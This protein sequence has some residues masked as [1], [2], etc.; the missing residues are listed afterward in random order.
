VPEF[1][2]GIRS[3]N[4]AMMIDFEE[5]FRYNHWANLQLLDQVEKCCTTPMARLF[6]HL[7]NAHHIWNQR[8]LGTTEKLTVWSLHELETVRTYVE[9]N[10]IETLEL[11]KSSKPEKVVHYRSS[12]GEEFQ[13]AIRD[14]LFQII[15]HSTHHRGQIMTLLREQGETPVS[16]DYIF[17]VRDQP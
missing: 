11:L 3:K 1:Q 14:I 4:H 13:S 6:S 7:I 12:Q 10:H 15:N 9:A 17:H 8:I 5:L 2:P 16:L